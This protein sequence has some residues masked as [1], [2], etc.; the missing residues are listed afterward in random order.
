[1]NR[2][3]LQQLQSQVLRI[4]VVHMDDSLHTNGICDG[5]PGTIIFYTKP[6]ESAETSKGR[7]VSSPVLS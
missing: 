5:S 4:Q 1:M 3:K 6:P 7:A 2:T